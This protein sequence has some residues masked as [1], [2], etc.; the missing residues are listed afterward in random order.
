MYYDSSNDELHFSDSY[1]ETATNERSRK[2]RKVKTYKCILEYESCQEASERLKE[3]VSDSIYR[4]RYTRS[5]KEGDKDFYHCQGNQNC[6]KTLYILRHNDS[7]KASIWLAAI[8]H[9]HNEK[10]GGAL[11]IKSVDHIKKLFEEKTRYSNNDLMESLK[12]HNLPPLTN[13]Q[14]NNLKQRIKE[15]RLEKSKTF[16]NLAHSMPVYETF[17]ALYFLTFVCETKSQV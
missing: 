3:A 2:L 13:S 8:S 11:P 9:V 1:N 5:T 4:F 12:T 6:P 14:I 16:F 7:K 17:S 10:K 15:K